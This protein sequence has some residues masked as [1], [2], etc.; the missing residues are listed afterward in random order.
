[1]GKIIEVEEKMQR[2]IKENIIKYRVLIFFIGVFLGIMY[3]FAFGVGSGVSI[4]LGMVFGIMFIFV[5]F[6]SHSGEDF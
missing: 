4:L 5:D 3:H 1:M 6:F 2:W